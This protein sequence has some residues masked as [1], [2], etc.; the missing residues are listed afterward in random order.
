MA[1]PT[2]ATND[3]T[4]ATSSAS[5]HRPTFRGAHPITIWDD[6]VNGFVVINPGDALPASIDPG[7]VNPADWS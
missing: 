7:S 2:E 6:A 1:K 5:A 4:V 3:Q